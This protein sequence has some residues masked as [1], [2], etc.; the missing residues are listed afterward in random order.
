MLVSLTPLPDIDT[1][2]PPPTPPMFTT[3]APGG[4]TTIEAWPAMEILLIVYVPGVMERV[5]M[6]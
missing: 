6:A 2:V 4:L 3:T 5:F 1:T